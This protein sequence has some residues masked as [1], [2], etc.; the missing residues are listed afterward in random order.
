MD[1]FCNIE[2]IGEGT[3]GVVYKARDKITGK[4]VALKRIRLAT[5]TEGV[6][7]TAIREISLLKDLTHPNIVQLF[8][9][10]IGD[11]NLYLV[12]EYLQKDLKKYLDSVKSSVINQD[13]WSELVKSYLHQLLK[14]IAFCHNCL[15]LHRDL[16]P[17]NLL[18]DREG[19][20]KLADFGLARSFGLPMRMYTHEVVTLWYR[21][22]E[23]LLGTKLYSYAID[24][25]SLGCIFAEMATRRALFPG[26][27][28][29][30]QLFRIF[31]TFGTPDEKIWPG[32]SQLPDYKSM[33]PQ[34]DARNLKEVVPNFDDDARDLFSKLLTYDPSQRI[35]ALSA[36]DHPFFDKVKLV[37]PVLPKKD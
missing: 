22:P 35:T 26:D 3:Y 36:T 29:I 13:H 24:I 21:A 9:V 14:A 17:Q 16:K 1:N 23:I 25:W 28:E 12:F 7:S 8:D 10:V 18:I 33:F 37:P 6:P 4:L 32:V 34:W 30:D 27:S 20:I 31:R 11:K 15:I 2:K 19:H 5:E